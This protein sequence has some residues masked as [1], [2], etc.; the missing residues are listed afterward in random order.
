MTENKNAP[1][2]LNQGIADNIIKSIIAHEPHNIDY[3]SCV[4][5][6]LKKLKR[7]VCYDKNKMPINPRTGNNAQSNNPSTWSDLP[8]AISCINRFPYVIGIGLELGATDEYVI[9][10]IDIDN[11]IDENGVISPEAQKIIDYMDSYTEISPSGRGIH[12]TFIAE[13]KGKRCKNINLPFCKAIEMY[14]SNRYFT[15]T[16]KRLNDK[17]IEHRQAQCDYIY[18]KYLEPKVNNSPKELLAMPVSN[19]TKSDYDYLKT[20]L[21][22][23][24]KFISIYNGH[25]ESTDESSNDCVFMYKLMHWCNNNKELAIN[26]FYNSPYAGRKDDAHKK[27]LQ[28]EDYLRRTAENCICETTARQ[29]HNDYLANSKNGISNFTN[30]YSHLDVIL[31][32]LNGLKRKPHKYSWDDKGNGELF[33][34]VFKDSLRFDLTSGEWRN[35]N[36]KI[37]KIDMRSCVA[38]KYA[39]LLKDALFKYSSNEDLYSEL[40]DETSRTE[41]IDNFRKYIIKLGKK[42]NRDNQIKD[43]QSEYPIKRED[44]DSNDNLFNCQNGTLDLETFEFREHRASDLLSK[45][46][47]V[48]YDPNASAEVWIK[49][50]ND[51]LQGDSEKIL[52]LQKALG[53]ALTTDTSYETCFILYGATTR[54]GKTTLVMTIMEMLGDYAMQAKSETLEQKKNNDSRNA[55]GDVA[56][57]DGARFLNV[58]EIP[59]RMIFDIALLK[60]LLGRDKITARQIYEK[61]FEFY[62]IFKLFI[63]TNYLPKIAD[64]TVF[65]SGRINVITF[66]RHFEPEEQ[67]KHLKDRLI[68]KDSLSGVLNWCLEGLKL[69]RAEGLKPPPNVVKATEEYRKNSDKIGNF[70]LDCLVES[71]ENIKASDV[72]EAY[73]KWC[74]GAGYGVDGQRNFYSELKAKNILKE[75]GTVASVTVRNVVCGFSIVEGYKPQEP[76][77]FKVFTDY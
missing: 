10:G 73:Q 49:F 4:P 59:K 17:G 24:K 64:D 76:Y 44:L 63:N 16:G 21:K 75:S 58:S 36:G 19:E 72:Y 67:D 18:D 6:E 66:D 69:F 26:T 50:I 62:P 9:C 74:K 70:I 23:D 29:A 68:Q 12:I 45:I 40:E 52:Y 13:K 30:N 54:N 11:C 14:D 15:F 38:H 33:A 53:Y 51:V 46:A 20:G 37:W 1:N 61:E 41:A 56:R 71:S 25:R 47:N 39:K 60:T 5:E 27:K 42:G 48:E 32:K 43:A 55:N 57:L 7:F 28:R 3:L 31:Q 35:Y 34:E 65:S 22:H 77:P 2:V 8:T